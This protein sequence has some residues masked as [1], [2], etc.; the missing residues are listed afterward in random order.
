MQQREF[1]DFVDII[2]VVSEQY[3]KRLSDGVIA[4]YWQGL[5]DFELI[6][7]RDAL[8][9][10]LRNTDTGQFM[11]KIAD[12]IRMLQGSSQDAAFTAW[13]KV[14]KAVRHVGPYETVVFDDPLIH[15]VLHDMGGWIGLS[16]KTDEE[17]P[18]VARDFEN[19]YRGFKSRNERVEYPSR[20][21]GI[22]EAHNAK[23]G[24]KVAQP[25]L[26][27]DASKANAVML[28]GIQGSQM[29]GL[30]RLSDRLN[31]VSRIENREAA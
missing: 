6:A 5:Q 27:G 7:V 25:M 28:E 14:D 15:R 11:P 18:F 17:W 16:Q 19:R 24:H 20:L 23:E 21:I 3:G 31:G 1:D 12:I 2:Q 30:T 22:S 9:R 13:S 10:H 4:L 29:L 26:I 8:G